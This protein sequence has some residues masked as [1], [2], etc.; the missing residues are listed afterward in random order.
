MKIIVDT[1]V[2]IS[3][4]FWNGDSNKIIE[5]V[6]SDKLELILSEQIIKEFSEVLNSEEIKKKIAI[7]N[8]EIQ[9]TIEKI[10]EISTIVEPKCKL[11]VVKKDPD[12]NIVLECAKEGKVD[13]ILTYDNHLLDFKKFEN[14]PILKPDAFL[15]VICSLL[16]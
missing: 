13:F 10:R 8:L 14:I 5:L 2:L 12:D 1:N 3:A 4:T 7:K 11:T 9:R 6:E 16:P 15:K